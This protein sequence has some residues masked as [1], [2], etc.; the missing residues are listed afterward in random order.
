MYILKGTLSLL[1]KTTNYM[2]LR[3]TRTYSIDDKLYEE[4]IKLVKDNNLSKSRLIES[5]IKD[6]IEKFKPNLDK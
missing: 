1:T 6:F 5:F 4:F 3:T 2:K